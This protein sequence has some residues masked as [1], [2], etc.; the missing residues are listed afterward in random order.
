MDGR[1]TPG[2]VLRN[3]RVTGML[4]VLHCYNVCNPQLIRV[5]PE[6]NSAFSIIH[7]DM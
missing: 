5:W 3:K 4:R 1:G 2:S 7:D 6:L